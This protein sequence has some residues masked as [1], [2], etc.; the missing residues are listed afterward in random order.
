MRR[1]DRFAHAPGGGL[2]PLR[3]ASSPEEVGIALKPGLIVETDLESAQACG[4]WFEDAD[5]A[6]VAFKAAED[7]SDFPDG[8]EESHGPA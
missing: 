3:Y 5:S 8:A 2:A 6:E 1:G 7:P 4:A